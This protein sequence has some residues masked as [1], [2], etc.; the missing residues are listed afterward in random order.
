MD[1]I[2]VQVPLDQTATGLWVPKGWGGEHCI[3][4]D[5]DRGYCGK[6]LFFAA[7]RKASY[8]YH[9]D[10]HETFYVLSGTGTFLYCPADDNAR[11]K[12]G[13]AYARERTYKPGDILTIP[14]S[15]PH[16]VIAATDTWL[17]EFSTFDAAAD[18]I[19]LEKGD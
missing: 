13:V 17:I 14:P 15:T 3:V 9:G 10:K 18:S 19:R 4:N 12:G 2:P 7:G 5:R 16:R 6:R 1:L 8:H 11:F